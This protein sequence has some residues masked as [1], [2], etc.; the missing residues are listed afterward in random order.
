MTQEPK[1]RLLP[2]FE[3]HLEIEVTFLRPEEGGGMGPWR[4]GFTPP[5]YYDGNYWIAFYSFSQDLIHPGDTVKAL[6]CFLNA[7]FYDL[8]RSR[9]HPGKPIELRD[10]PA[11]T[12]ARG[13]VTRMIGLAPPQEHP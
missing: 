7:E 12:V 3:P 5:F 1:Y 13:Q 9:L 4:Q 10:P 11:R 6:V 8:H 2:G